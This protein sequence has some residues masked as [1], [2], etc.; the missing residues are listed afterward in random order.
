MRY[1]NKATGKTGY[2]AYFSAAAMGDFRHAI[3]E[4]G[5]RRPTM[6]KTMKISAFTLVELLIALSITALLLTAVATVMQAA[7]QSIEENQEIAEAT[8][9]ARSVLNRISTQIRTAEDIQWSEPLLLITPPENDENITQ[10]QY[11]LAGSG[12][13]YRI[14]SAS[15]TATHVLISTENTETVKISRWSVTSIDGKDSDGADCT[16]AITVGL[17][18]SAGNNTFSN[19]AT[20]CPRRKL[21]F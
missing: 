16:R 19:S 11:E 8:Q 17:D 9:T 3:P 14:A 20:A 13:V 15:G 18:I 10:Y 2:R 12:L 7:F 1:L 5:G 4:H 6:R 21:T